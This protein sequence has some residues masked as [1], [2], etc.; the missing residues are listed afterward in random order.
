MGDV[1]VIIPTCTNLRRGLIICVLRG[2]AR[3][4]GLV[5][6]DVPGDVHLACDGVV[7]LP[8][9]VARLK[10][11]EDALLGVRVC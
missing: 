6:D 7:I 4:D 9:L 10:P 1:V 11:N 5:K 8:A 3:E 2:Q